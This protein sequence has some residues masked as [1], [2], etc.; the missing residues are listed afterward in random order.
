MS[1]WAMPINSRIIQAGFAYGLKW[2]DGEITERCDEAALTA[3]LK[4]LTETEF[5]MTKYK[6]AD[7]GELDNYFMISCPFYDF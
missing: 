2:M 3:E 1:T 7:K 6:D 4:T 5:T